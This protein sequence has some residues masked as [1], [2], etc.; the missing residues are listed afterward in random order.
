MHEREAVAATRI[1]A[2]PD[3]IDG[4]AWPDHALALRLAPDEVLMLGSGLPSIN[5]GHAI[6]LNDTGWTG[7]RVPAPNA[8]VFME[9]QCEWPLPVEGFAQ[10][11]VAGIAAKVWVTRTEVRFLVPLV[12]ADAFEERLSEVWE[13]GL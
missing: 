4:A 10:G 6:V 1:V 9:Q 2:R 12:V 11:M 13:R 3:A 8:A 7:F 5:D